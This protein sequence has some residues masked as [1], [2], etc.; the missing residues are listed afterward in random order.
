MLITWAPFY[1]ESKHLPKIVYYIYTF[2]PT[3]PPT[4]LLQV[5]QS[6]PG[7]MAIPGLQ[8]V[9]GRREE[10]CAYWLDQS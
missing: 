8:G 9:L 6:D 4:R 5:H 3:P 10:Q 2:T 7:Y 1:Q